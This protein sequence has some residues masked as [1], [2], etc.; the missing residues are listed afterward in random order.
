M[1]FRGTLRKR[2]IIL[3]NERDVTLSKEGIIKY[4][5]FDKPGIVKGT[6]DLNS[7]QEQFIRFAYGNSQV[8]GASPNTRP[9]AHNDDEFR[10]YMQNQ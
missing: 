9:A 10:V 7:N 4:Y 2:G 6:I 5:H 8:K 1:L 3:N